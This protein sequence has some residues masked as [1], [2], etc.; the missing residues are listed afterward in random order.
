MRRRRWR[1]NKDVSQYVG[2]M[3][4][5]GL[6]HAAGGAGAARVKSGVR[7]IRECD[8]VGAAAHQAVGRRGEEDTGRATGGG[9]GD[10]QYLRAT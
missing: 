1:K 5:V 2:G 10:D 4:E 7:V 8:T 9:V 3:E 6:G